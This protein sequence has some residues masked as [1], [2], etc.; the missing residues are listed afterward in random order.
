MTG[1]VTGAVLLC[2]TLCDM[3]RVCSPNLILLQ[4]LVQ[5]DLSTKSAFQASE[6]CLKPGELAAKFSFL[7]E[8]H[9]LGRASDGPI[10]E[11]PLRQPDLLGGGETPT[12]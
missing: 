7:L 11:Q 3:S 10:R 6:R 1:T 2:G 9:D 12:S 8:V 5:L 4:R